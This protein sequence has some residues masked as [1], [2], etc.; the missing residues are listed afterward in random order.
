MR[1]SSGF[2]LVELMISLAI[3][4]LMVTLAYQSVDVLMD[5]NRRVKEPQEA[6]QQLQRALMFVERDMHQLV[7]RKRN[8]GYGQ[9][10]AAILRPKDDTA[11]VLLE[12]IRGGNPDVAWELR[13][14]GLMRSSL[15]RVR[16]VL[17]GNQ[18]IR[19]SWNLVDYAENT[20]P[21]SLVLLDGV[22]SVQFRF[23]LAR[24][25]DFTEDLPEG[26]AQLPV[27]I[28]MTLEHEVFGKIT[29]IFL[30]YL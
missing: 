25:A 27:A 28:E 16:Y 10:E 22:K 3:F 18:L 30:S 24:D 6:F 15:Q 7:P 21:V 17:E 2:T 11:G 8:N 26:G 13:A 19:Q 29:R 4:A 1:R 20:E 12:F 23:K 5:A 9:Q 14:S